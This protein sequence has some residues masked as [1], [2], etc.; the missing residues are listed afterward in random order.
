MNARSELRQ[1]KDFVQTSD[2]ILLGLFYACLAWLYLGYSFGHGNHGQEIPPILAMIDPTLY[3]LDFSVQEFLLPGPRYAYYYL[4]AWFSSFFNI[5]VDIVLLILKSLSQVSFYIALAF[6]FRETKMAVSQKEE[7]HFSNDGIFFGAFATACTFPLLSWGSDIFYPMMIPSTL[8]MT[9]AIW[10]LYFALKRDWTLAFTCSAIATVFQFLVGFYSGLILIPALTVA[11]IKIRSFKLFLL[12][13]TIFIMPVITI[14]ALTTFSDQGAPNSFS[15][16]DVFGIFRVPHHWLPSTGPW[17]S[18]LSDLCLIAGGLIASIIL[19]RQSQQNQSLVT[20]LFGIVIVSCLGIIL[21]FL[22]VEVFPVTL[23]GK[24]Q[25]QRIIPF[26]HVAIFLIVTANV[27][28]VFKINIVSASRRIR[29]WTLISCFIV[30][31]SFLA[32]PLI[33]AVTF[34]GIKLWMLF[35]GGALIYGWLGRAFRI[36]LLSVTLSTLV[37]VNSSI[38]DQLPTF[39]GKISNRYQPLNNENWQGKEISSWLRENSSRDSLIIIPP[40][41]NA[42]SDLLALHSRR[43][44]F[45][46]FKNVPYSNYG[47]W[48]WSKRIEELLGVKVG[49]GLDRDQLRQLWKSRGEKKILSL[50]EQYG[51]CYL[52]DRLADRQGQK[53]KLLITSERKEQEA[54]GLWQLQ[55]CK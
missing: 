44:V 14:Y 3:T 32:L 39:I 11:A 13:I 50:A 28:S 23:I 38:F 18:W 19:W 43:S 37:F 16:L 24:L 12:P 55:N 29:F 46:S 35:V 45:F 33:K 9:I 17:F 8:A 49:P 1:Q 10:A 48:V 36:F 51:A 4:V 7:N 41:W 42:V 47:V 31:P 52:V 26:A 15:F 20:L 30:L 25:F 40:D 53:F 54:W 34:P 27:Y 2:S 5:G 6:I 21:N 22:F